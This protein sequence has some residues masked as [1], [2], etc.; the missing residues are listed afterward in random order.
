MTT[1]RE[2]PL[3]GEFDITTATWTR[4]KT[5]DGTPGRLEIGVAT[6]GLYAL[7]YFDE[8]YGVIL[9]YTTDEWDA[10]VDGVSEGEFDMD[11]LEQ[12]ARDQA[13]ANAAAI[14]TSTPTEPTV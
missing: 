9:I 3:K 13:A 11:V 6:N 2:H 8:P 5:E 1:I 4:T 10:F 14:D 12:D 7:R